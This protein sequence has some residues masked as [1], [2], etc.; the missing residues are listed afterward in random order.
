VIAKRLAGWLLRLYP[1][2][3]RRRFAEDLMAL[4]GRERARRLQQTGRG[5]RVILFDAATLLALMVGIPREWAH[6]LSRSAANRKRPRRHGT[7]GLAPMNILDLLLTEVRPVLRGL[8]RSPGFIAVVVLTL[9][10]GFAANAA[11]FEIADQLLLRPPP[12]LRDPGAVHKLTYGRGPADNRFVTGS[13]SYPAFQ[14]LAEGLRET[15]AMAA[16]S[17]AKRVVVLGDTPRHLTVM[18]L[19]ASG[20][21]L[22]DAAPVLGRFFG[23]D[24]DRLP[25]GSA[26]AVLS[27]AFWKTQFGAD[28]SVLG[29]TLIMGDRSYTVIGV[30]PPGFRGLAIRP[31]QI[32]IPLTG[33]GFSFIHHD[34]ATRP[35]T[36]WL[37]VAVRSEAGREGAVLGSARQV[38]L[39]HFTEYRGEAW[40]RELGI[41]THLESL[42]PGRGSHPMSES[43]MALWLLAMSLVLVLIAVANVATL[44]IGRTLKRRK[45]SVVRAALG[46]RGTRALLAPL[47]ETVLLALL[48]GAVA[49]PIAQGTAALMARILLPDAAGAFTGLGVRS[50]A[51]LGLVVLI[52]G[53]LCAAVTFSHATRTDLMMVLRGAGSGGGS[54]GGVRSRAQRTLPV[55]QAALSTV[56]LI[57]AGLFVRSVMALS[58]LE[59]G[60]D[61]TR[62]LVA[63]TRT[64]DVFDAFRPPET[65]G[66]THQ[67]LLDAA[68]AVPSVEAATV[69]ASVPFL[70]NSYSSLTLPGGRPA[71]DVGSYSLNVVNPGYFEV[72]GTPLLRGRLLE[73]GDTPSTR[74]VAVV[75]ETLARAVWPD[76]DPIGRRVYIDPDTT[77]AIEV[78][79][80]VRDIRRGDIRDAMMLQVYLP[81]EQRTPGLRG[82]LLVRAAADAATLA[83]PLRRALQAAVP[84]N[85]L[86]QVRPLADLVSDQARTWTVG[87]RIFNIFGTL[88]LLM[89]AIG[90]F[91]VI[92]YE[93][94][95][96]MKEFGVRL[97]LGAEGGDLIRLVLRKGVTLAAV[98]IG[99][100]LAAAAWLSGLIEDQL[101]GIGPRDAVTFTVVGALLLLSAAA[102][103]AIPAVRA[104]RVDPQRVLNVE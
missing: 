67:A 80:I 31:P 64:S 32:F 79:G 7:E 40:A 59:L 94:T 96:R 50:I 84:S 52:A 90:L 3:F 20:W 98:G 47:V 66:F 37:S 81:W 43:R 25:A 29:T 86:I 22:F 103:S 27:H 61:A 49:V 12:Y 83:Q 23:A 56:L 68:R 72:M 100:G 57:G 34:Y 97:A 11:M 69:S 73:A 6:R 92:G 14:A 18:G 4:Y 63:D 33:A 17:S 75:S 88:A 51:Y 101:Y 41:E 35:G 19:S 55:V 70:H 5:S 24:E 82:T 28:R 102:A 104:S 26:V 74:P 48:A 54:G 77:R 2:A 15:E 10:L 62:V 16:H 99:L 13:L 9:G 39:S 71:P 85:V 89:A 53:M 44:M 93:V 8:R 1:A 46:L 91:S 42:L 95:Q 87:S 36:T 21:S 58:S 45:E 38:L 60:Y 65:S 78:V 30:A 76:A